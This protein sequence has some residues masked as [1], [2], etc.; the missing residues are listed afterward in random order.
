[1][2]LTIKVDKSLCIGSGTCVSVDPDNF[3]LN[4]EGKST[5][6]RS[7][8]EKSQGFEMEIE[9]DEKGLEKFLTAAKSCPTQAIS[10]IDE[11]GKQLFP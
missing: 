7:K 11:K 2:K 10:I 6:K 5:I 1:M 4:K 8:K 3:E 9:V